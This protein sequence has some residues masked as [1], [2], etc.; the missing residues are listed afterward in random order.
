MIDPRIS[1]LHAR[2][3]ETGQ[4]SLVLPTSRSSSES[5]IIP[6]GVAELIR[7]AWMDHQHHLPGQAVSSSSNF[8]YSTE[9]VASVNMS[10]PIP[11]PYCWDESF[12]VF[13]STNICL[14]LIYIFIYFINAINYVYK[15]SQRGYNFIVPTICWN[16]WLNTTNYISP[17]R[18]FCPD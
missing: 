8:C 15:L 7:Q 13:V 11:E 17:P 2:A 14:H 12:K 5:F 3:I 18:K 10:M 16:C 4:R 6:D 9:E 1:I